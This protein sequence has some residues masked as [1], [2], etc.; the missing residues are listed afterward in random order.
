MEKKRKMKIQEQIIECF[1]CSKT[2]IEKRD[3][4]SDLENL[5]GQLYKELEEQ[6]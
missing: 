3:F 4:L 1:N 5:I 6:D 2:E